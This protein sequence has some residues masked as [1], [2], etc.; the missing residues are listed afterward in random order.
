MAFI[1]WLGSNNLVWLVYLYRQQ[2][3]L[4]KTMNV[5]GYEQKVPLHIQE[6]NAAKLAKLIQEFEFFQRENSRLD[7]ELMDNN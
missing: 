6:D 3:K 2:E 7:A 1:T 5:S 4:K